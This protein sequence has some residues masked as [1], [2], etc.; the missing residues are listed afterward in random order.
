MSVL[1][2]AAASPPRPAGQIRVASVPAGHVYVR[3]L[4]DPDGVRD[5]VRLPDIPPADGRRVPGGW[6][7]PAM[8]D[9]EW[10]AANHRH[11]RRLPR[12]L[13][14]RRQDAGGAAQ[15]SR[16]ALEHAG[17]PLVVTVHD[18]R[19]P[20]HAEP[21]LPRRAARDAAR[22]RGGRDHADAGG[23]AGDRAALGP[24]ARRCC[25][26]P[27]VVDAA[28]IARP[29]PA[30][31]GFVV[32][33]ARQE[34]AG[35][36]G[37]SGGRRACWRRRSRRCRARGCRSTS[38]TRCSRRARTSTTR[39][40]GAALRRLAAEHDAVDAARARLLQ[41]TTSCGTT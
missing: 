23:R 8:L 11:L 3:H 29:R 24:R 32:G 31:R 36:H 14:V 13:R 4:S 5:V 40:T 10:I 34:P 39:S 7:P 38:T 17:V 35:Q 20:H 6:W 1:E 12:A 41:P 21:E 27:H 16:D 28:R 9:A 15:P 19:N 25:A 30:A 18:L 26:H 37:R 2:A 22:A 33:A